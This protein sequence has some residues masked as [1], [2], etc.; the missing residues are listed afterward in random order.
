MKYEL[1]NIRSMY[2]HFGRMT[3]VKQTQFISAEMD[4]SQFLFTNKN[5]LILIYFVTE[6][7]T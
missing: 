4:D 5:Y 2:G 7:L 3:D 6:I 1:N